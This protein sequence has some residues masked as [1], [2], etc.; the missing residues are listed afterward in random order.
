MNKVRNLIRK[1]IHDIFI[2]VAPKWLRKKILTC[3]EI[4]KLI[5]NDEKLTLPTR[6]KINFHIFICKCCSDYRQQINIISKSARRIKSP[7]L[8]RNQISQISSNKDSIIQ[9]YTK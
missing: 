4:S 1:V 5:T 8:T 9:K 3:E 6:M 2:F 7:T